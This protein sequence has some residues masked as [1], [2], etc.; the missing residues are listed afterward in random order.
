MAPSALVIETITAPFCAGVVEKTGM[1]GPG[2]EGDAEEVP[3]PQ[4]ARRDNVSAHKTEAN[5]SV[6]VALGQPARLTPYMVDHLLCD[7]STGG[8][9]RLR[10]ENLFG[11]R[12]LDG[13]GSLPTGL[14]RRA[15]PKP[16]GPHPRQ[17]VQRDIPG[18]EHFAARHQRLFGSLRTT[19]GESPVNPHVGNYTRFSIPNLTNRISC[20]WSSIMMPIGGRGR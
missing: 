9:P 15:R 12:A 16:H 11:Q 3:P 10:E 4:D 2:L 7:F 19:S 17:Q 18:A 13:E 6:A 20:P 1:P 14:R 8:R 5:R